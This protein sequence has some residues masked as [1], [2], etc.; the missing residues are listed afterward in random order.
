MCIPER[1]IQADRFQHCRA[2]RREYIS[3]TF[4]SQVSQERPRVSQSAIG[5]GEGGV[6]PDGLLEV[7]N[8]ES[9]LRRSVLS[10]M[11]PAAE[12]KLVRFQVARVAADQTFRLLTHEFDV[13]RGDDG[14]GDFIL[15]G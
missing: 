15:D 1:V 6:L 10:K 3:W 4:A 11:G 7:R 5:Q 14:P 2:H 12:V 9:P 13:Q 8:A